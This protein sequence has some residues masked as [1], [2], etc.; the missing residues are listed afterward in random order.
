MRKIKFETESY[1]DIVGSRKKTGRPL[2]E[3]RRRGGGVWWCNERVKLP[4]YSRFTA[5][6]PTTYQ[7]MSPSTKGRFN[8]LGDNFSIICLSA[9][10]PSAILLGNWMGKIEDHHVFSSLTHLF[11]KKTLLNIVCLHRHTYSRRAHIEFTKQI[12]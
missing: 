8:I 9:K 5:H 6:L 1:V 11:W 7:M 2:K 3:R 10:H 4:N 12:I